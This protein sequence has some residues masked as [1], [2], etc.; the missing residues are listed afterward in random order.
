MIKGVTH[1]HLGP[2]WYH[3]EPSDVPY[4]PNQFLALDF[5]CRSLQQ[6][7]SSA[8]LVS[9]TLKKKVLWF[10]FMDKFC[11]RVKQIILQSPGMPTLFI[12]WKLEDQ[13][14]HQWTGCN[15]QRAFL[16]LNYLLE[17]SFFTDKVKCLVFRINI[18]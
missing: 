10:W 15:P 12:W 8:Y 13:N 1:A 5:F 16:F 11:T 9:I 18:W 17:L 6:H 14:I 4:S 2:I 3:S 7:C